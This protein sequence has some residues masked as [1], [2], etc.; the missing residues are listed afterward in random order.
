MSCHGALVEKSEQT[1]RD[2]AVELRK[3]FPGFQAPG[4]TATVQR[5]SVECLC[6]LTAC[7][8]KGP[9]GLLCVSLR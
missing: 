9:I 1:G 2:S 6:T 7:R 3:G 4:S 5:K 8:R